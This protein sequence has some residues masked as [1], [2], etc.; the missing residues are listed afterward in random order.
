MDSIRQAPRI[1]VPLVA[2]AAV[3]DTIIP[4]EHSERLVAAWGGERRLVRLA[5]GDHN[6]LSLYPEYWQG[7][8]AALQSRRAP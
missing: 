8:A 7:I 6:S 2:L 3:R 4:I 1:T 5:N